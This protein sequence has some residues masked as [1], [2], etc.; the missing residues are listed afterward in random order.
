MANNTMLIKESDISFD[1]FK[2]KRFIGIVNECF[3][4][5]EVLG[6]ESDGITHTAK[7]KVKLIEDGRG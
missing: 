3:I 4:V 7:V 2:S 5:S 1:K 6:F